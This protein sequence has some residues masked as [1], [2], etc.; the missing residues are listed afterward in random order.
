MVPSESKVVN[1]FPPQTLAAA[2]TVEG[3]VD[4]IGFDYCTIDVMNGSTATDS[5]AI[6]FIQ[7]SE[8]DTQLCTNY[9]DGTAIVA[10]TGAAATSATAGFILPTPST[11]TVV[12]IGSHYRFNIDLKARM[13][14]LGLLLTP[15]TG[16]SWAGI[17]TL[18]RVQD[19][20]AM[21]V[22]AVATNSVEA[23]QCRLNVST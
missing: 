6:T 18:H 15:G 13:R 19:S 4:T 7:V 11:C 5:V 1:L 21:L 23:Y 20:P 10:L 16:G 17:A 2:G 8:S 22:P 12:P 14:Y 9:T 3:G